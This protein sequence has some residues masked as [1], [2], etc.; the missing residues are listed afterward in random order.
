MT[1]YIPPIKDIQFVLHD[2]LKISE[3][4]VPGYEDLDPDFTQAI[5]DEAGK[6]AANVLHPLNKVGDEEGC[7]LENGVVRTPKGFKE[8]FDQMYPEV[9][10]AHGCH[11]ALFCGRLVLRF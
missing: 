10:Q 5:L 2:V 6:I 11:A 3:L 8:A 4:D 7:T 9:A 1:T